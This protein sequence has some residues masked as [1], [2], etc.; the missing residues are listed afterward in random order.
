M[1][2]QHGTSCTN[3][4]INSYFILCLYHNQIAKSNLINSLFHINWFFFPPAWP[5]SKFSLGVVGFAIGISFNIF[6]LSLKSFF[7][8]LKIFPYLSEI[9]C[10]SM[11]CWLKLR[12]LVVILCCCFFFIIV[13]E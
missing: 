6:N 3:L 9:V 10:L 1:R 11:A 4:H 2:T 8:F 5:F 13:V 12:L 7:A